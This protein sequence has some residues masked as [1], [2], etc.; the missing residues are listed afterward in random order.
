MYL[1][2]VE[3]DLRIEITNY[4]P[5]PGRLKIRVGEGNWYVIPEKMKY[6]TLEVNRDQKIFMWSGWVKYEYMYLD[7]T[8]RPATTLDKI[9]AKFTGKP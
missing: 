5:E 8:W 3:G 4:K 7:N 1:I 6:G 2:M 9:L